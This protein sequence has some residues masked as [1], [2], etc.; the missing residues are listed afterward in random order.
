MTKPILQPAD[1]EPAQARAV[2]LLA[3]GVSAGEAAEVLG[4][5]RSTV[6]RWR[7]QPAFVSALRL[8][9]G[10]RLEQAVHLATRGVPDMVSLL[11]EI[12]RDPSVAAGV[13]VRAASELVQ[14]ALQLTEVADFSSRLAAVEERM[15]QRQHDDGES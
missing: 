3:A 1:L 10:D 14:R 7:Q 4:V 12:A 13:R 2:E 8:A 9:R 5:D 15:D 11:A 6:W